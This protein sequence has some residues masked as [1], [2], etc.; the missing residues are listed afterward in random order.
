MVTRGNFFNKLVAKKF[1]YL[2]KH[3]SSAK[4]LPLFGLGKALL[5]KRQYFAAT[6]RANRDAP[7]PVSAQGKAT[8]PAVDEEVSRMC[9]GDGWAFVAFVKVQ[10]ATRGERTHTSSTSEIYIGELMC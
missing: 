5:K 9:D 1:V 4:L 6:T 7:N 10:P 8:S 2:P 3:F